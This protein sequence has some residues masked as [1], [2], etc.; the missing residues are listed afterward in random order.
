MILLDTH[1]LLWLD[2]GHPRGRPL[3]RWAGRLYVSPA[4]L[5]EVE[6]LR[7][8]G[9]IRLRKGATAAALTQDPRW[10][11]DSPASSAWFEAAHA[12]SWAQDPFDR[13]IVAHAR[14]RGWRLATADAT[15]IDQ[16]GSAGAI[17]L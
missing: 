7:E 9:R 15:I 5:L 14:H 13:L 2:R 4:S 1:A 12:L 8:T 3:A 16:L 6:V 17:E 10:L 11:V